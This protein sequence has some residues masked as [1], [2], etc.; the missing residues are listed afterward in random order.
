MC[1]FFVEFRTKDIFFDKKKFKASS[2]LLSHRGPD[3]NQSI[4]LKN[5][6]MEFYRLSIR[7]LSINGNQP[8][9]DASKRFVIVFNGEIYNTDELKNRI[10]KKYKRKFRYRNTN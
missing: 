9:W 8:M 7:D 1:G 2:K 6:S 5:I 3:Q 4:Y 10:N